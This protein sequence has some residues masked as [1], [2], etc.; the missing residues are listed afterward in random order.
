[1]MQKNHRL[2][3]MRTREN[4]KSTEVKKDEDTGVFKTV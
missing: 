1:M 3:Y 2:N 4:K